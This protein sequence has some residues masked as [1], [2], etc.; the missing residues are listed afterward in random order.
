[1]VD[2]VISTG[3][4]AAAALALIRRAGY[5][6]AALAVAM[7]QG[8]RWQARPLDLP[9]AGVFATPLFRRVADG[10]WPRSETLSAT[11]VEAGMPASAGTPAEVT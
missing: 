5:A 4:S 1:M 6:P 7:I 2:D 8:N 3:A 10:W 11:F 9:V